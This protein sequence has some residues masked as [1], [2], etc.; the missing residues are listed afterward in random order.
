MNGTKLVSE[1]SLKSL[2]RKLYF[3]AMVMVNSDEYQIVKG[4]PRHLP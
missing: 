1:M 4:K 3:L 2:L